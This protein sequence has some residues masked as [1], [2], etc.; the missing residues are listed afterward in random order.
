MHHPRRVLRRSWIGVAA[1]ASLTFTAACSPSSSPEGPDSE[2]SSVEIGISDED[3]SLD[4]LIEAAQEEGPITVADTS[5]KIQEVAAGFTE[6]YGIKA[7]PVKLEGQEMNEIIVREA[8]ADNV[9]T[10]VLATSDIGLLLNRLIPEGIAVS[11][12]PPDIKDSVPEEFHSPAIHRSTPYVWAYNS[13]EYDTCPIDNWWGATDEDRAG[14]V[15]LLDP[16]L[17]PATFNLFNQIESHA[18]DELADAYE[19]HYGEPLPDDADS[20]ASLFLERFA[21][22][23]PKLERDTGSSVAVIGT[24]GQTADTFIGLVPIQGFREAYRE[25]YADLAR[26]DDMGP[27]VGY[28]IPG[29]II[30]AAK[31]TKPN[32]AK[33]FVHYQMTQEGFAP[34]MVDGVL[35]TNE[36]IEY[37]DVP[38]DIHEIQ[39]ELFMFDPATAEDD[40]TRIQDWQDLWVANNG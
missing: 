7:T 21:A 40:A 14:R 3:Y 19:D 24:P 29:S 1:V 10:D 31:T 28:S 6:K 9:Q 12:M 4:A 27:W 13:A 23:R 15:T 5:G 16:L 8:G 26:C 22:N 37:S 25:Q 2:P 18:D 36:D 38:G 39:D 32:A 30:I 11:W 34:R 20:A 33:L 17:Q 35:S